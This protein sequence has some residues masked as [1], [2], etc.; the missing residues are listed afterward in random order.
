MRIIKLSRML[1]M[2]KMMKLM[3]LMK[4]PHLLSRLELYVNRGMMGLLK[5]LAIVLVIAHLMVKSRHLSATGLMTRAMLVKGC[6][7]LR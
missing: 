6:C 3:R 2:L 7:A 1:K 5:F 4:M